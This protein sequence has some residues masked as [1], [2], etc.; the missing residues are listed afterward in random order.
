LSSLNLRTSSSKTVP[1]EWLS[2]PAG[3]RSIP[4]S[5]NLGMRVPRE[6]DLERVDCS[7]DGCGVS[8][9]ISC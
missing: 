3:L 7:V 2:M 6:S 8:G 5:R 1:M 4:G 9:C